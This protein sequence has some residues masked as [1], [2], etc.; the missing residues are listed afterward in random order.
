MGARR[1]S[2]TCLR[3]GL[4][5]FMLANSGCFLINHDVE[6]DEE[7]GVC[8][9]PSPGVLVDDGRIEERV[10]ARGG[11]R[12]QPIMW[13]GADFQTTLCTGDLDRAA[14]EEVILKG[15]DGFMVFS[16]ATSD[17]IVLADVPADRMLYDGRTTLF[18]D[19]DADGD[20]EYLR[21]PEFDAGFDRRFITLIDHDGTVRWRRSGDI[22]SG[23]FIDAWNET[24]LE[25]G[26]WAAADIDGDG[27]IEF[28]LTAR[29]G[30]E[31]TDSHG[32]HVAMIG[33][34]F[35]DTIRFADTNGDGEFELITVAGDTI[36]TWTLNGTRVASFRNPAASWYTGVVRTDDEDPIDRIRVHCTLYDRN[37]NEVGTLEPGKW[38]SCRWDDYDP[39]NAINLDS[40]APV[41]DTRSVERSV[42]FEHDRP[43][44]RVELS[45]SYRSESVLVLGRAWIPTHCVI[46][47][48]DADGTL[49]YHEVLESAS[50]PGSITVI[51]SDVEGEEIL[52]VADDARILSYRFT[53]SPEGE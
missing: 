24:D 7:L 40:C 22:K 32:A 10:W 15:A 16:S 34:E 37:G 47:I 43:L 6:C 3:L 23:N 21:F 11:D 4:A 9:S 8:P 31:I 17:S 29:N 26:D 1:H 51:P 13:G 12:V 53:E 48:F 52:L 41:Q 25:Y 14:G 2:G 18:I 42:R 46:R 33:N 49:V 20:A 19:V 35:Y 50:A 27:T 38:G 45:Y 28:A 5:G 30:V 39:L 36:K 44:Y